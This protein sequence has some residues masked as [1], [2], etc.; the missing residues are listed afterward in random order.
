MEGTIVSMGLFL[1]FVGVVAAFAF[2]MLGVRGRNRVS[3]SR[4]RGSTIVTALGVPL[5]LTL[6][7]VITVAIGVLLP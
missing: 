5:S 1:F 7:G 2:P 6:L 4:G 3:L